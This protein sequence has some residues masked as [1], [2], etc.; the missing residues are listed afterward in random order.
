MQI[1]R[2]HVV[3]SV[4]TRL[5]P[6]KRRP[7]SLPPQ[8][9][10]RELERSSQ[11]SHV[12]DR[13]PERFG[14]HL[15]CRNIDHAILVSR[16]FQSHERKQ[17][18]DVVK[19]GLLL[20][21][22][23]DLQELEP[24][25][26]PQGSSNLVGALGWRDV[27]RIPWGSHDEIPADYRGIGEADPCSPAGRLHSGM[28]HRIA[29]KNSIVIPFSARLLVDHDEWS[30]EFHI[31]Q[32]DSLAA[33][34]SEAVV[35]PDLIRF[36]ERG[37]RAVGDYDIVERY[38][39]QEVSGYAADVDDAVAVVLNH[40]HDVAADALATPVAIGDQIGGAHQ[41]QHH[42]HHYCDEP[43]PPLVRMLRQW[44]GV[45]RSG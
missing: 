29:R 31:A 26:R 36:D 27:S 40:A 21:T 7:R 15:Q 35:G 2:S 32:I 34:N 17:C 19:A 18:V 45:G 30:D 14:D 23:G 4:T 9:I 42:Y 1:A 41:K 33:Q 37:T 8:R 3:A 25:L 22:V 39:V 20:I 10:G 6:G 38:S 44:K 13:R 11:P 24:A 16:I 43:K 28:C 12:G 5:R